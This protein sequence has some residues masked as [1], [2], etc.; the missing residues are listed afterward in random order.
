MRPLGMAAVWDGKIAAA[1]FFLVITFEHLSFRSCHSQ[2]ASSSAE[3]LRWGIPPTFGSQRSA[4]VLAEK[5]GS[6]PL[7]IPDE[8]L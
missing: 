8:Q 5:V 4:Y 7:S 2:H 6:D 1:E 3:F